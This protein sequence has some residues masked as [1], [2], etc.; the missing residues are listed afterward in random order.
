[1]KTIDPNDTTLMDEKQFH[2]KNMKNEYV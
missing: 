1:M 2:L